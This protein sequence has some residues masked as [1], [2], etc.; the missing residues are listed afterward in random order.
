MKTFHFLVLFILSANHLLGQLSYRELEDHNDSAI[1]VLTMFENGDILGFVDFPAKFLLSTDDGESW[2]KFYEGP[3]IES[4]SYAV[5]NTYFDFNYRI[6]KDELYFPISNTLYKYINADEPLEEIMNV[7]GASIGGFEILSDDE[8]L[9][10]ASNR[11]LKIYSFEGEEL[12][13]AEFKARIFGI[14]DD[15]TFYAFDNN[16]VKVYDYD[17]NE[18]N[19]FIASALG[20][21]EAYENGRIYTRIGFSDD[22]GSTWKNYVPASNFVD[23]ISN[24]IVLTK[25]NNPERTYISM[26]AGDTFEEILSPET[27]PFAMS[28]VAEDCSIVSTYSSDCEH[29]PIYHSSDCGL[30]FTKKENRPG[31]P[32]A[33]Q[34][35]VGL[36]N[37]LLVRQCREVSHYKK[38][39][40]DPWSVLEEPLFSYDMFAMESGR[41]LGGFN[42]F[43]DN[44][45]E[46]W[47]E[48]GFY[49]DS[50]YERN[51]KIYAI[52]GWID[53][54]FV[55][56][57]EGMTWDTVQLDWEPFGVMSSGIVFGYSSGQGNIF[58]DDENGNRVTLE[59]P[60]G[61]CSNLA[62]AYSVDHLYKVS[63]AGGNS[64]P[65]TFN[66]SY[67][68]GQTWNSYPLPFPE[69]GYAGT[70]N[71][72]T[73]RKDRL[74][75]WSEEIVAVSFDAGQSWEEITP[76]HP[77]LYRIND[78]TIGP[79]DHVYIATDGTGI[80]TSLESLDG[81]ATV[82]RAK[83]F[84]DEDGDCTYTDT[85]EGLENIFVQLGS[86]FTSLTDEN[87][88][89]KLI[90]SGT[91]YEVLAEFNPD[92]YESCNP[93]QT[94]DIIPDEVNNAFIPLEIINE[95]A[96]IQ[97]SA[98][99]PFLR[100]CFDNTMHIR[101][102]NRGSVASENLI[103]MVEL[104]DF[105][106]F[107][108]SSFEV[109]DQDGSTITLAV[110]PIER[111]Q[112]TQGVVVFNI[113]CDV[114]LGWEHYSNFIISEYDNPCYELDS[115]SQ[116][117]FCMPNIGSW[118]PN[119]KT[120]FVDGFQSKEIIA[121]NSNLEYLVRFQNTGSDTAF[122]V[123][124]VDDLPRHINPNSIRP[125]IASHD[126][127]WHLE[128]SVMVVQFPDIQLVDSTTNEMDSHGFIKF[129]AAVN[130]ST[131][132]G[133]HIENE[134]RIYFD[135]NEPIITNKTSNY[136]LCKDSEN[137]LSVSICEGEE[138]AGYTT[139]GMYIDTLASI[140]GCD[141][142]QT[143]FLE[144]LPEDHV[145]CLVDNVEVLDDFEIT[146]YPN[147]TTDILYL[148]FKDVNPSELS[149]R[150]Y[151]PSGQTLYISNQLIQEIDV[152]NLPI[153]LY[154]LEIENEEGSVLHQKVFKG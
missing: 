31:P 154:F 147:P 22:G 44:G 38:S 27:E 78:V 23:V 56:S 89:V 28:W 144:V 19:T 133:M 132:P 122:N 106:D 30:S 92:F 138:Y 77:D 48:G 49:G 55:S 20:Y 18:L 96:D 69:C 65:G 43:S 93:I 140:F 4:Y 118:D 117:F 9:I 114:E 143:L 119:D 63:Y 52:Q 12:R 83:V 17:L 146:V 135:F 129:K 71:L 66:Y 112:F 98:G 75:L 10:A 123:R 102:D 6:Y 33:E 113:S 85:E 90:V 26:D 111:N 116:G 47:A 59:L 21:I 80:L 46:T 15:Q 32:H 120:A 54:Y 74:I 13:T 148:D 94:I 51:G 35:V 5:S 60:S 37:N 91:D 3:E 126:F 82:L 87:G 125:V 72:K 25:S 88:E 57:N 137:E 11:N 103:I 108:S 128:G 145:D 64:G 45:G 150:I 153:G 7:P 152:S 124:I 139:T 36:D 79:D 2:V 127:N 39:I 104:D 99:T 16:I 142:I 151:A 29:F 67:D 76:E 34:I 73:D 41:L 61:S 84:L 105:F 24:G 130:E 121:E 136:Y 115:L 40:N 53:R 70:Y 149:L 110:D 95:C 50:Y 107:V 42:Q 100:R 86:G 58:Y 97:L 141:S 68:G 81:R 8:I 14:V 101:L 134:A 131:P 62:T 109:V 1:K